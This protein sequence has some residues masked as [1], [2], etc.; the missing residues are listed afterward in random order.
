MP[1]IKHNNILNKTQIADKDIINAIAKKG[2]TDSFS[3]QI[4]EEKILT[5]YLK[6]CSNKKM[7]KMFR[8]Y[9]IEKQTEFKNY[10]NIEKP[11]QN[12]WR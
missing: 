9:V 2:I 8:Y 3:T 1:I 11:T 5:N 12:F 7:K 4:T 6:Y 10:E